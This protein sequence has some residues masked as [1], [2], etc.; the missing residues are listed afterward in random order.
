MSGPHDVYWDWG[1][2]NDAIGALRRLAGEIDSAA[3]RRA[4]ATTEL[5]GSWEGPRQQEWLARYATMQ[6]ASIR[7]RERCLQV[8]NA[9]AQASDRARAEQDRINHIRAE[10][11][12]LA[13]QQR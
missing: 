5:L 4:R 11:E 10:Q 3:N 12:R 7:L 8:A 2:A 6:T 9:I 13:Q 1:A